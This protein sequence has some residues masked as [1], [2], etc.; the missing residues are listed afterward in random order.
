V[1]GMRKSSWHP[2]RRF[3]FVQVHIHR[4]AKCVSPD[5]FLGLRIF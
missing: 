1:A 5:G 4:V 3:Y 2:R